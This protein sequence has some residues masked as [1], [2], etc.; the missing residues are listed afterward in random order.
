MI[1]ISLV[2][3]L[4]KCILGFVEHAL[5]GALNLL[6]LLWHPFWNTTWFL[7]IPNAATGMKC[8]LSHLSIMFGTNSYSLIRL[9]TQI[10][11]Q[12]Q[13]LTSI[14]GWL[15]FR[16]GSINFIFVSGSCQYFGTKVHLGCF[17][18]RLV[19]NPPYCSRRSWYREILFL[20]S[21]VSLDL[22]VRWLGCW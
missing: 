14:F 7:C 20:N 2:W 1:S 6:L 18:F 5:A 4:L 8:V 11:L 12:F 9:H 17:R 13:F 10:V 3:A 15:Q 16:T 19:M 21:R 22:T